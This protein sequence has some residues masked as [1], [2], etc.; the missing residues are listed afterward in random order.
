MCRPGDDVLVVGFVVDGN[1]PKRLLLRGVGPTLGGFGVAGVL[2]D[3]IL[4]LYN[5][6]R[7]VVAENDDWTAGAVAT[8]GQSIGA[9]PLQSGSKDAALVYTVVP[10]AFTAQVSGAGGASGIALVEVY[11]VP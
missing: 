1:V 11:E 7:E 10:G 5:A 4:R 9:F 2:D 8:V 3:P 6:D